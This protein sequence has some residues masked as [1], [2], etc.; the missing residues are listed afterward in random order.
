LLVVRATRGPADCSGTNSTVG[1]C[2]STSALLQLHLQTSGM[3]VHGLQLKLSTPSSRIYLSSLVT[4]L[5]QSD[6]QSP[7]WRWCVCGVPTA[8]VPV[9]F[10]SYVVCVVCEHAMHID[11]VSWG[12][13]ITHPPVGVCDCLESL[14]VCC[15]EPTGAWPTNSTELTSPSTTY[16]DGHHP[17]FCESEMT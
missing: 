5:S 4:A 12:S 11:R 17:Y 9:K 1:V 13:L 8:D 6:V 7:L 10:Q 2:E 15:P 16:L 3:H 14:A